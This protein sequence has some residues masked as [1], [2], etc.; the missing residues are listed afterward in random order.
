ML[1]LVGNCIL[2]LAIIGVWIYKYKELNLF[3]K[4]QTSTKIEMW[5]EVEI[6]TLPI[7]LLYILLTAYIYKKEAEKNANLGK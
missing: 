1:V 4:G 5:L 6:V 7:L 2:Y 3:T